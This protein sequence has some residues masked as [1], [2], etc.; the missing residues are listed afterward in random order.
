MNEPLSEKLAYWRRNGAPG[1]IRPNPQP[2]VVT[3]QQT[4]ERT[5]HTPVVH[6]HTG[7]H[8]GRHIDHHDGHVDAVAEHVELRPN[9]HYWDHYQKNRGDTAR[10]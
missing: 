3:D 9:P 7:R 2:R 1:T 5:K 6:E 4:G 10:G 8:V